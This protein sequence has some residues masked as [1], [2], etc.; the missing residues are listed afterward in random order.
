MIPFSQDT[1]TVCAR[2]L[3]LLPRAALILCKQNDGRLEVYDTCSC[4]CLGGRKEA[5]VDVEV[6]AEQQSSSGAAQETKGRGIRENPVEAE[7]RPGKSSTNL[8]AR[9]QQKNKEK[10]PTRLTG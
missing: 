7:G 3:C 9:G 8:W 1:G 5:E 10:R 4:R 6:A 2:V